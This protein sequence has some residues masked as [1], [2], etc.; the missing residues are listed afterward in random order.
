[1]NDG[2]VVVMCKIPGFNLIY[3]YRNR[4]WNSC[5]GVAMF[6]EKSMDFKMRDDIAVN[7]DGD[8]ESIFIKIETKCTKMIVG[9]IAQR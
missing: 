7:I 2:N 3:M 9:E 5:D 1:M 8:F 6:I 4:Q